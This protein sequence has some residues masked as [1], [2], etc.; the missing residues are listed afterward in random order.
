M[1]GD[2][3]RQ[4]F[5]PERHYSGVR[6]QQGRVQLDADW[7]EQADIGRYRDETEAADV[8]GR[9]GGPLHAAAF[10]ITFDPAKPGDF[11]LG[12]GRYY[13]DGMLCENEQVVAYTAQP[14]L[15]G[16]AP[17]DVTQAG[18]HIAY[19]DVWHRHLT[20]LDDPRLRETA[21][22]GPDTAT[23]TRTVWQVRTVFAGAG[24]INCLSNP[25]AFTNATAASSALLRA[26]AKKETVSSDPCIVPSG[27]G[28]RGLENQLYRVEVHDPGNPYDLTAGGGDAEI[29]NLPS[30]NQVVYA[31]GTWT[32]G[33]AVEIFL[34]KAGSEPMA[35]FLAYVTAK[36]TPSKTLTLNV[37]LPPLAL[38]DLP[39]IR[40]VGS[41]FKW[42]RDNGSVV[43]LVKSISGRD[44]VV[45]SLGPDS[46]LD[47]R[48]GQWLELSDD[49]REL[50]GLPGH[51]GQIEAVDPATSTITLR[52]APAPFPGDVA[53]PDAARHL[54][55]R[56]WD[57]AGAAKINSPAPSEGYAELE[58]GVQIRFE[59][60]TA[61][62]GDHWLIPARTATADAQ[63]GTIEWPADG[64]DPAAQPPLGIRHHYCKVAVL[65][66]D[67]TKLT[68]TDCRSL[69]PPTTELGTL[70]YVGGDGQETLPGQPMPQLLEVGVFRGRS[71]V[72]NAHVRFTTQAGG[73]L[74][75]DKPGLGGASNTF[76]LDTDATG[77][78]RCAWAPEADLTEPSQ[79]VKAELLDD[80]G[81]ALPPFV[82]FTGNLSIAALVG[83]TPDP[84]CADLA[85]A[86]TVQ[87]AL[88]LL[89]KR[90]TGGSCSVTVRP[91]QRLDEVIKQL[92]DAGTTDICLCLASGDH[93]LPDAFILE[94]EG[95]SLK[96]AGCGPGT[97]L[98]LGGQ[99]GFRGLA[100]V[101]VRELD[102]AFDGA[103]PMAFDSCSEVT[104]EA[105]HM[106]RPD[107]NGPTIA[108]GNADRIRIVAN[109][110]DAHVGRGERHP[111]ETITALL[112]VPERRAFALE[113]RKLGASLSRSAPQRKTLATQIRET[114]DNLRSLTRGEFQSYQRLA[115][116]LEATPVTAAQL[117]AD[118]AHIWA[119]AAQ[120]SLGTALFIDD[121]AAETEI[122]GN[123]LIG[124]LGLYGE[125][126]NQVLNVD[127]VKNL[128][129]MLT[130]GRLTL[131]PASGTL[132]L[133][134]NRL[135]RV[136][137]SKDLMGQLAAATPAGPPLRLTGLYRFGFATDN[138]VD[139]PG[140]C[141]LAPHLA[142]TANEFDTNDD[143]GST[144]SDSAVYTGNHAPDDVRLFSVARSRALAANLTINIVAV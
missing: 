25:A 69:F 83:Y 19:L 13:V 115:A 34:S 89:C 120:A 127:Q 32:V 139:A 65:Q 104:I 15:P 5:R 20:A 138:V 8:I 98:K 93:T 41:T 23:R 33:Q 103:R 100:A 70:V 92:L 111:I 124:T 11:L 16:L 58:D 7:N 29:T 38:A 128:Q 112:K 119:T 50:A 31:S 133:R 17:L 144:I 68:A 107:A 6:M 130:Q 73:R 45:H 44:V 116:D 57:G 56:R 18:F 26:R 81:T 59:P 67:G 36:H 132:H 140:S 135:T 86:D 125:P 110:I 60:G 80:G 79:Q 123:E 4:T 84:A 52:A 114:D 74:A 77:I 122:A 66:S 71:P 105:C 53:S 46:V 21:L 22:G 101:V 82:D 129:T 141:I 85:G 64:A 109:V 30:P 12:A 55:A 108:I 37:A 113:A 126:D 24:P 75:A 76:S 97:R 118:L 94:K 134:D 61:L 62:T 131:V 91:D 95:V 136:T 40:K 96:L 51:L 137:L 1:K 143:I 106:L 48:P 47:F 99:L 78:A 9:C 39:R 72:P 142:L 87:E 35:G 102:I 42:S 121:G 27:A 10:A 28:F 117:A 43:A 49:A 14:D 90:P 2:F 54:K 63:S 88:D 3:T